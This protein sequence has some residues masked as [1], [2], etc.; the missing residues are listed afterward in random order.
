[1]KKIFIAFFLFIMPNFCFAYT[2][3]KGQDEGTHYKMTEEAVKKSNID[4][5]LN[6]YLAMKMTDTF[7]GISEIS[8]TE[9]SVELWLQYGGD[10]EDGGQF[11]PRPLKHFYDPI[12]GQGTIGWPNPV[13]AYSASDW[14]WQKARQFYRNALSSMQNKETR[15]LNF[16]STFRALGQIVHLLQDMAVPAHTR[17]DTHLD[18][19]PNI[20]TKQPDMYEQ[21]TAI[22]IPSLHYAAPYV[23]NFDS[24]I[25]F[26]GNNNNWLA[27]LAVFTNYNF[28]SRN[29]N[30]DD[31]EYDSPV[32]TSLDVI[33]TRTLGSS[34]FDCLADPYTCSKEYEV[35]YASGVVHDYY[36]GANE[37]IV[38]LSVYSYFDFESDQENHE[39]IY[40]LDYKCHEDYAGFLIPR[41]V[42]YSAGLLN[43]FFRGKLEVTEPAIIGGDSSGI[44]KIKAKVINTTGSSGQI[45][46]M[47]GGKLFAVAKYKTDPAEEQFS[48]AVS[49]ENTEAGELST[50][51]AN[52]TEATFIFSSSKVPADFYDLTVQVGYYGTIGQETDTGVAVSTYVEL[53]KEYALVKIEGRGVTRAFVWDPLKDS[54]ADIKKTDGSQI[55]FPCDLQNLNEWQSLTGDFGR[56]LYTVQ[57]FPDRILT[58]NLGDPGCSG[59]IAYCEE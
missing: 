19:L 46:A 40:S 42:G 7:K 12:T 33:E 5:Y 18:L 10:W 29:T 4:K 57:S 39:R 54:Y 24:F 51:A 22:Q 45:E 17:N 13:W 35:K 49:D 3:L 36:T 27:G 21:Y 38:H 30:I 56:N 43:Y 50:D 32:A 15:E 37:P 31:K 16:A 58:C 6:D 14:S 25:K 48:Y 44:T 1:M 41:A 2:Q 23:P 26:W 34:I 53:K 59:S 55:I 8:K 20:I 52:P 28:L 47:P 9:L 11:S